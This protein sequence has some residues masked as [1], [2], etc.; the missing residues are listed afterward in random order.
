MVTISSLL[1]SRVTSQGMVGALLQNGYV[2][3]FIYERVHFISI[4]YQSSNKRMPK[5]TY[6]IHTYPLCLILYCLHYILNAV[7]ISIGSQLTVTGIMR[8]DV[9]NMCRCYSCYSY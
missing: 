4:L 2:I 3:V 6:F 8:T 5:N 9:I 1:F 7:L